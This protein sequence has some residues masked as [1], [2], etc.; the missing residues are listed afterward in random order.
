MEMNNDEE[1]VVFPSLADV[2]KKDFD[3]I[4]FHTEEYPYK[5]IQT[6][7]NSAW[8]HV[9]LILLLTD[10]ELD[11]LRYNTSL[12]NECKHKYASIDDNTTTEYFNQQKQTNADDIIRITHKKRRKIYLLE[13]T[14]DIYPCDVT[15]KSSDGVKLC[16]LKKRLGEWTEGKCGY[17]RVKSTNPIRRKE[18]KNKLLHEILPTVLGTPYE[19]NLLRFVKAWLHYCI[20]TCCCFTYCCC[21]SC[22]CSC[23]I[24][25]YNHPSY[26]SNGYSTPCLPCYDNSTMFCT[27][28]LTYIFTELNILHAYR[29]LIKDR[30]QQNDMNDD[31]KP[32]SS[33]SCC[34]CSTLCRNNHEVN[35]DDYTNEDL[36]L[37]DYVNIEKTN[38]FNKNPWI[39][40]KKLCIVNYG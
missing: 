25:E 38:Y 14:T 19:Q 33:S 24:Y 40:Y 31:S 12:Y 23:G 26:T 4:F 20:S 13:S 16:L 2:E 32:S 30:Q 27:E 5:I 34:H 3:L 17:K 9:G 1:H 11:K 28:L 8:C 6:A 15:G 37:E 36:V 7:G 18:A 22:C 21:Y 29:P 39:R 35:I 10:D